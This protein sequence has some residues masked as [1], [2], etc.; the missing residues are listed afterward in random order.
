MVEADQAAGSDEELSPDERRL[1]ALQTR[2]RVLDRVETEAVYDQEGGDDPAPTDALAA[3]KS[4]RRLLLADIA[5]LEGQ[6][7]SA[8]RPKKGKGYTLTARITAETRQAL[9]DEAERTGRSISQVAERW[10]E[11]GRLQGDKAGVVVAD[12]AVAPLLIALNRVWEGV[13]ARLGQPSSSER[14]RTAMISAFTDVIHDL[15]P[16]AP[17]DGATQAVQGAEIAVS[18]LLEEFCRAAG[19]DFPFERFVWPGTAAVMSHLHNI[20]IKELSLAGCELKQADILLPCDIVE[21]INGA[22]NR[23]SILLAKA[24]GMFEAYG[25]LRQMRDVLDSEAMDALGEGRRIREEALPR[26]RRG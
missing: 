7:A 25:T 19:L 26:R 10:I 20:L 6:K 11:G 16:Q 18:F 23:P 4:E 2:L 24:C 21:M 9:E 13:V 17:P 22:P 8:N 14:A 15:T 1:I 5:A 12:I 3:I